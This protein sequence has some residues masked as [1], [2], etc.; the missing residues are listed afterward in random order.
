MGAADGLFIVSSKKK[1]QLWAALFLSVFRIGF[2]PGRLGQ[3]CPNYF[4]SEIRKIG[5][6]ARR[7]GL[8]EGEKIPTMS[9]K[10]WEGWGS[11]HS[12]ILKHKVSRLRRI[13]LETNDPDALDM[14]TGG[15]M[16]VGEVGSR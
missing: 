13:I 14:T 12:K 2:R 15:G 1:A 3:V 6:K 4:A 7:G 11:R 8:T 16:T 10:T 5:R 9:Q